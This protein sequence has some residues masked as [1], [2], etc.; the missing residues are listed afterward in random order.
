M[1]PRAGARWWVGVV[2]RVRR[3][4]EG[5]GEEGGWEERSRRVNIL[6]DVA[7]SIAMTGV[8]AELS[9][10]P[11]VETVYMYMWL[12]VELMQIG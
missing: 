11:S 8:E 9:T 3:K 12:M 4:M 5:E 1:S 10:A 6:I 2:V 7:V